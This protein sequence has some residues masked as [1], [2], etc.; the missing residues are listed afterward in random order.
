MTS[1]WKR[2]DDRLIR[3]GILILDLKFVRSYADELRDMNDGRR[4]RPYRITNSFIIFLAVF[5]YVFSVRFRQLEG[6]TIALRKMFPILPSIDYSWIRGRIMRL[7][8]DLSPLGSNGV[9]RACSRSPG[10]YWC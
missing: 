9:W 10:L 5:R 7:G 3:R 6:F 1:C 2:V 4:G 8:I